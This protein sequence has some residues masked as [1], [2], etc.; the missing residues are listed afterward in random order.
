MS[1]VRQ[2]AVNNLILITERGLT[3]LAGFFVSVW[4]IR[5]FGSEK[6][7]IY[8]L[9]F[10]WFTFLNV[11]T[12][13]TIEQV[14]AREAV[15]FP[16]KMRKFL[17][18]GVAIKLG[19]AVLGWGA[20]IIAAWLLG[21]SRQ[22]MVYLA[23]AL[24]GLLGNASYVLQVPHQIELKLLNP[25]LADGLSNLFYQIG[26]A[27]MVALKFPLLPFFWLY[28]AFRLLQLAM[29]FMLGI[30]KPEYRLDLRF[31]YGE[32][33]EIFRASWLLLIIN[34]FAMVIS[35]IDQLMLF[36]AW[37]ARAVGLYGS[38]A[39]LTDYLV[40]IP[41]V[42]YITVFPLITRYLGESDDTF[43]KAGHYSFK[44]MAM[45]AVFLWI[46]FAGF[47]REMLELL[48]GPDYVAAKDAL[49]WLSTSLVGVFLYIGL[50]NVAL[51]R[52]RE[53]IWILVNGLGA[54]GN[55][56]LNLLLIP[57]YGIAGAGFANFSA[58]LIQILLN[59]LLK[60]MRRD[61]LLMLKAAAWP[62]VLG[63]A[64]VLCSRWFELRMFV[65]LPIMLGIYLLMLLATRSIGRED[66]RLIGKAMG[67][68][69]E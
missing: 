35:R 18:A 39:N 46:I 14:V 25:A 34:V 5:Y 49:F 57:R 64:I 66:L 33:K 8:S 6:F 40:M 19:L 12:P 15:R 9:V 1:L 41:S 4:L 51:S 13:P 38:C 21:Y 20:G 60:D 31:S 2:I 17:G 59:A 48:F 54:L 52:G 23:I 69:R 42:W 58:Y 55:L 10:A 50:F 45:A 53:K 37:G 56:A 30:E 27:V 3:A 16:Q 28:L 29:F 67:W 11:F 7:G 68:G 61:F 32:V 62:V 43:Q 26:R 65:W 36:P 24:L 63:L 47:S 22:N 44:Y